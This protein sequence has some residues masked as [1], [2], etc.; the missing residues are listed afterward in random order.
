MWKKIIKGWIRLTQFQIG[1]AL[2]RH[3]LSR[4]AG[5]IGGDVLDVG[6][7]D[8]PY[9]VLLPSVASYTATNTRRHYTEEEQRRLE[10]F[11]DVWIEDIDPLPFPDGGFDAVLCFQVLSV[12]S[13]PARFFA[14]CRRV[15]RPGGRLVL[16]TDFL[17]PR[18][19]P[20]DV[21]R[22]TDVHLGRLARGAG[23]AVEVLES[24]GGVHT[25]R[26]AC[27]GRY[28]ADYPQRLKNTR[29][30]AGRAWCLLRLLAYLS[31]LPL[32]GLSGRLIYRRE[33]DRDDEF[34]YTVNHLL[35]ARK[36]GP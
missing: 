27:L 24:Y 25:A 1:A 21:M 31:A 7:G 36:S 15:L 4:Y 9:R 13:D 11:T 8:Q 23:L 28:I 22:H 19:S 34:P 17:F 14:E 12:I 5:W 2:T 3:K 10:A 26:Y 16:T 18:W 30:L 33:R 20:E 32:H 29:G 35:I 6:A